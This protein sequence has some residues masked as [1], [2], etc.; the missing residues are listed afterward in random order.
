MASSHLKFKG[1]MAHNVCHA[2]QI[3]SE[4]LP[5]IHTLVKCNF[6]KP[7]VHSLII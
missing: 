1:N 4:M 6:P 5:E 3:T 2:P 7:I